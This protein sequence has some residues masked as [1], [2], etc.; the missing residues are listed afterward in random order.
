[1]DEQTFKL[2]TRKFALDIIRLVESLPRNR[3]AK[4]A[5]ELIAMTVAPIKTLRAK[6]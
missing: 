6:R 2:R 4:E 1:M 3:A 5:N